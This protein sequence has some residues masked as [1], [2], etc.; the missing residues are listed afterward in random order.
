[1]WTWLINTK[2]KIAPS[3]DEGH[4]L[5]R[6]LITV[7]NLQRTMRDKCRSHLADIMAVSMCIVLLDEDNTHAHGCDPQDGSRINSY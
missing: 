3:V 7:L 2:I 1:M 5:M 4:I 6:I